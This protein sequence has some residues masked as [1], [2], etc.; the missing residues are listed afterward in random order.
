MGYIIKFQIFNRIPELN[1]GS[2]KEGKDRVLTTT[3]GIL[4][5]ISVVI[6]NIQLFFVKIRMLT[7]AHGCSG[8]REDAHVCA[9]SVLF[10][11][12]GQQFIDFT[13]CGEQ[14]NVA[15][16]VL[17]STNPIMCMKR[18]SLKDIKRQI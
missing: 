4:T 11:M 12:F 1:H 8:M 5:T 6:F 7:D 15:P 18:K 14:F 2:V 13:P 3:S 10:C 17:K 16:P 9:D